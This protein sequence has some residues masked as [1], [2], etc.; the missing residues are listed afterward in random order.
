MKYNKAILQVV[1]WTLVGLVL[2]CETEKIIFTGP[3]HIRFTDTLLT[4]KESHS[5]PVKIEVHL[6]GPQLAD[7]IKATY[8]ISGTAREGIDYT[9]VGDRGK[10]TLSR[11]NSVGYITVQLI[12][13]ANNILRSQTL[14]L[15][16]TST[17]HDDVGVGQAGGG[18]GK[19]F[20]FTI[21]DDCILGGDYIGLKDEL[22]VPVN[23]ITIVSTDCEEYTLSNWDIDVFQFAR[24]RS[25]KFIDN[26]DN[27]LTIPDQKDA[28]LPVDSA[29]INGSGFVDPLTQDI[30]MKVKLT[31][32][33][34]QPEFSFKLERN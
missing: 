27:T 28:T 14:V 7:D 1:L 22:S 29:T 31:Q 10:L 32:Y 33:K 5:Q 4:M 3:Y 15:T 9:I 34:G 19:K 8:S 13:N 30:H 26:G 23:D 18:L 21:N 11:E 16:L 2:S 25:L 24:E 20:V 12:N 6:A 17:D